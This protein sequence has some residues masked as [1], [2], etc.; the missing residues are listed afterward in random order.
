[1]TSSEW[2]EQ[3]YSELRVMAVGQLQHVRT[4]AQAEEIVQMA[5]ERLLKSKAFASLCDTSHSAPRGQARPSSF[6]N[7]AIRSV[8]S[9]LTREEAIAARAMDAAAAT[10]TLSTFRNKG[11]EAKTLRCGA[12][13]DGEEMQSSSF[14]VAPNP[15][16]INKRQG[17][18]QPISEVIQWD[19]PM[20]GSARWR[21]QTLRDNRLFDERA[22]RSLAES[23][24]KASQSYRHFGEQ[25]FAFS[26]FGEG[27]SK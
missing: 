16:G 3:N 15:G 13:M 19:G 6:A 5:C 1:M 14:E 17:G 9:N 8:I 4:R 10:K 12:S 26:E 22:V 18:A 25:G 20:P 24:H 11:G 23:M 27:V 2:L 7:S 21:F